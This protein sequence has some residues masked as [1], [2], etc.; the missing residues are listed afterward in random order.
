LRFN[1]RRRG[2]LATEEGRTWWLEHVGGASQ[3]ATGL[4]LAARLEEDEGGQGPIVRER[5]GGDG[6]R[7]GEVGWAAWVG[8]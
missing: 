3:E 4:C 7:S 5:R 1:V 6:P 2:G 8:R